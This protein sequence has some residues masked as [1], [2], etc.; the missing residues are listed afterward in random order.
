MR[1][2]LLMSM[3]KFLL[4]TFLML[5]S[6]FTFSQQKNGSALWH[7]TIV[8][9]ATSKGVERATVSGI[10]T[11]NFITDHNG[12]INIDKGFID[13]RNNIRISCIGYRSVFYKPEGKY[14]DTLRLSATMTI[15]NEVTI[16][17]RS[18]DKLL[19]NINQEAKGGYYPGPNEEIVEYIPN[20]EEISGIIIS[21]NYVLLNGYKNIAKPFKVNLYS[22]SKDSMYPAEALIKDSIIVYNT[23]SLTMVKVDISKYNIQIPGDGFFIGFET[24]SSSWYGN[25]FYKTNGREYLRVPGIKGTFKEGNF[26]YGGTKRTGVKYSLH[27]HTDNTP[28]EW[29]I[30]EDGT[31]FAIGATINAD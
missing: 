28:L 15:L 23:K 26:R 22:K 6:D 16:N 17:S 1:P 2:H 10:S 31:D 29:A 4:L 5:G 27:R 11:Y 3:N 18:K 14:P 8:D 25:D 9:S 13:Q 30:F 7:L 20:N 24:L 21:V 12:V 19:G